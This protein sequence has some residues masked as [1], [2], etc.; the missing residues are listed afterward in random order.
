MEYIVCKPPGKFRIHLVLG[1]PTFG[2]DD[3]V[4]PFGVR[5][6]TF[7][8]LRL[9]LGAVLEER[10]HNIGPVLK[11]NVETESE[12]ELSFVPSK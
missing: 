2:E 5:L 7:C 9:L 12:P 6:L 10:N 11:Q 3:R 8:N 1:R 4:L